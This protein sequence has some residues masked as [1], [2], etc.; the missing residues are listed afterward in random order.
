MNG[1]CGTGLTSYERPLYPRD[2][3]FQL[4][5]RGE[6]PRCAGRDGHRGGAEAP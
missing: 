5:G 1:N 6:A 3:D 4:R 2:G